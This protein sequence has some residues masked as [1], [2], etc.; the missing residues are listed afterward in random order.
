M[1]D[2]RHFY[3]YAR[4]WYETTGDVIGDL[5]KV[6]DHLMGHD[7]GSACDVMSELLYLTYPFIDERTFV[8]LVIDSHPSN[9]WVIGS[10]VPEG[11]WP[12][13]PTEEGHYERY[14]RACL[15]L[16]RFQKVEDIDCELGLPDPAVLPVSENGLR[17]L[18]SRKAN[19][20]PEAA[21]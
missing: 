19:Q 16:L 3:L 20:E 12:L 17:I 18:E 8:K 7:L 14:A 10:P 15:S 1:N 21:Q 2:C 11:Q 4:G 6:Y 9:A 5:R 13:A